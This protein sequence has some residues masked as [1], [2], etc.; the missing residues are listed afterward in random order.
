MKSRRLPSLLAAAAFILPV[1]AHAH[2]GH[3]GDHELVWDVEHFLR[4]PLAS[5]ACAALVIAAGW[6][7]WRLLRSSQ[8]AKQRDRSVG[9]DR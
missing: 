9:R 6:A 2:P 4:H 3:D 1:L 5:I 7:V 8:A